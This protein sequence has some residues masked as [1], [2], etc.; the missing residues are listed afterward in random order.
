MGRRGAAE[1]LAALYQCDGCD[2]TVIL[3]RRMV[4]PPEGLVPVVEL[5]FV[6]S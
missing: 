4:D 2:E 1:T 3:Y 5:A 6:L